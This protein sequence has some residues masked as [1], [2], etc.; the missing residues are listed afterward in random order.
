MTKKCPKINT[1]K[2]NILDRKDDK[3]CP[4]TSSISES[5]WKKY[6]NIKDFINKILSEILKSGIFISKI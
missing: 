5:C 6:Q 1:K 3:K 4:K 2:I